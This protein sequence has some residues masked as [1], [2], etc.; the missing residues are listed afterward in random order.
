VNSNIGTNSGTYSL[1]EADSNKYITVT[2]SRAGYSGSKTS[3]ATGA[4]ATRPEYGISLSATGTHTFPDTTPLTVTVTNTGTNATG[5]LTAALSGTNSGSFSLSPAGISSIAAGGTGTFTVTP[6]GAAVGTYTA[7]VTVSGGNSISASFNV[8]Y[9]V[10]SGS[11]I[12]SIS[13]KDESAPL[14]GTYTFTD[15]TPL[16]VTVTNTGNQPTGALTAALSG[17]DVASFS[18]SPASISCIAAGGTITFTLTQ[19]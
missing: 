9:T 15:A 18:L 19:T 5:A 13:L 16:S 3:A 11:D 12:Y 2:V 6:T 14:S 17:T 7:T 1:V 8:S 10:A 4:V